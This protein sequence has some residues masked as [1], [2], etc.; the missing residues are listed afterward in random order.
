MFLHRVSKP[1]QYAASSANPA[2]IQVISFNRVH[3]QWS[4]ISRD[5]R[6]HLVPSGNVMIQEHKSQN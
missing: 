4:C 6:K 1:V 5:D 2:I 3:C